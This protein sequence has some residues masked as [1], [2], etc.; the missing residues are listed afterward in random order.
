[1]TSLDETFAARL[2]AVHQPGIDTGMADGGSLR[3]RAARRRSRRGYGAGVVVVVVASAVTGVLLVGGASQQQ[4]TVGASPASTAGSPAAIPACTSADLVFT[5]PLSP[6]ATREAVTTYSLTGTNLGPSEC[7][8]GGTPLVALGDAP[9]IPLASP[10]NAPALPAGTAGF[11]VPAGGAVNFTITLQD[12]I[13]NDCFAAVS[14]MEVVLPGATGNPVP[15]E[16]LHPSTAGGPLDVLCGQMSTPVTAGTLRPASL[17][18]AGTP[19]PG[20][21]THATLLPFQ[22]PLAVLPFEE[23]GPTGTTPPTVR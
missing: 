8:T 16:Q 6:I 2:G 23:P 18:G 15:N 9:S 10:T 20:V 13:G 14:N 22:K 4:V 21:G 3:R 5:A 19:G 7:R 17:G 12:A 1:M 11:V